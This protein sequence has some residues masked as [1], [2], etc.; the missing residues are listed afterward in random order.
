MS[1]KIQETKI[2]ASALANRDIAFKLDVINVLL[3]RG[4]YCMNLRC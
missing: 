3:N 4:D 1:K 2:K